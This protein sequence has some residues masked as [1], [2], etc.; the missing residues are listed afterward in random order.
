M[1]AGA[2]AESCS[3]RRRS[4]RRPAARSAIR[5]CCFRETGEKVADVET[6]TRRCP[7][8]TVHSVKT[9]RVR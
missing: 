2:E 1:T 4:M 7:G 5:A 9:D 6:P 3:T 8:L